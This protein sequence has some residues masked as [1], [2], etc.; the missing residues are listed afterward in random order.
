MAFEHKDNS[1]SLFP[2][3]RKERESQPDMNGSAKINGRE[4]WVK[5]WRKQRSNGEEWF[6][7]ALELKDDAKRP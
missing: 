3:D 7:L 2:N 6:S 5:G 1:G 4:Y